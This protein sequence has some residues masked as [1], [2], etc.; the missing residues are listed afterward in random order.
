MRI[1]ITLLLILAT[2]LAFPAAAQ[3]FGRPVAQVALQPLP[4]AETPDIEAVLRA[5]W[6][7]YYNTGGQFGFF[8]DQVRA[9]RIDL[10][11]DGQAELFILIDSPAWNSAKGQP[12][13]VARWTSKGWATVGWSFGD[14]DGVFVTAQR[15]DGWAT[16]ETPSQWLRWNGVGYQALDKPRR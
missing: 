4:E 12:L 5:N 14:S 9:G 7:A 10:N 13:L 15:I 1:R 3:D 8:R 2:V 6:K 11:E 16:I